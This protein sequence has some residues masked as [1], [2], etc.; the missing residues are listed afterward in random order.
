[1]RPFGDI[2]FSGTETVQVRTKGKPVDRDQIAVLLKSHIV[3]TTS[4]KES[5]I[6][7]CIIGNLDSVEMPPDGAE[8][9]FSQTPAIAGRRTI[10][11]LFEIVQSGR[12]MRSFWV[13][14]DIILRTDAWVAAKD[15]LPGKIVESSDF[16]KQ[17]TPIQDLRAI[18]IRTLDEVMGKTAR[19]RI[20]A[21]DLIVR[22]AFAEPFLI[23]RGETVQLR[24]QRE[25]IMLNSQARAEEDGKLGQMIRVRNQDFSTVIK[26]Q[27]IG[28]S[29]VILP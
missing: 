9:R 25:G 23:K 27:V 1:M 18:Y 19:H 11:A 12:T 28:R 7:I 24:L 6:E 2:Q 13:N 5:D 29:Q 14:A 4:W 20:S 21:G 16:V 15:I 22:E 10:N 8:L 3:R 26:A 17:W